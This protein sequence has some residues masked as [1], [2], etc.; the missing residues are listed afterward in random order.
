MRFIVY[1]TGAVGGILAGALT[2]SGQE[3]IAIA[4]G[5]QLEALRDGDLR[6]HTPSGTRNVS[7]EVVESPTEIEFEA[8]DVVFLTVKS[9]NT[10][11]VVAS[12]H[13]TAGADISVVCAQNGVANE[14]CA[15]RF[16]SGVYGAVVMMPATFVEPGEVS[17][18]G[19]PHL[20]TIDIGRYPS[21]TDDVAEDVAGS[22]T[23]A[24]FDSQATDDIMR[25]KYGKLVGNLTNA[26]EAI[27]GLGTRNGQLGARVTEEGITV[28]EAA[29]IAYASEADEDARRAGNVE[30]DSV[31]GVSRQGASSWQSVVRGSGSIETSYLNGEISLLG[32]MNGI[33]TPAN[34]LVQRIAA[35]VANSRMEPG[36]M[37][38]SE[39]LAQL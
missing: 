23:R 1:G 24:G 8:D 29:G 18:Y 30:H 11:Q 22:L 10:G 20:G 3:T 36:S 27:C 39:I 9:Q 7:L 19:D 15:L 5:R 2:W 16:F 6:L 38:E 14:R 32:R 34:S 28:L 17:V 21:G 33:P 13:E 31:G 25:W 26:I 37:S 12:L 35:Q 4:R